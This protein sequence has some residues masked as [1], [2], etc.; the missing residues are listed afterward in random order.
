MANLD[1]ARRAALQ[2]TEEKKRSYQLTFEATQPANVEVLED[3]ARFCRATE[4]CVIP[5]DHDRTLILEGR[6]E[7]W[8]RI[9]EWLNLTPE[10]LYL[11]KTGTANERATKA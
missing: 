1:D 10:Q 8:L 3:L 6:R 4:S 9:S 2:W 5:G 11:L 7:V